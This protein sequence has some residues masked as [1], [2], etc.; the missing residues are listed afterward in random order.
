MPSQ[1][2]D[3]PPH[4]RSLMRIFTGH[5]LDSLGCSFFMQTRKTDQT[6]DC[7]CVQADLRLCLVRMSEVTFSLAAFQ[8]R[9]CC[10]LFLFGLFFFF[11]NKFM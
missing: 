3:K 4:S 9:T 7:M 10:F 11:N 1:D 5:I 2:S 8:I 6:S